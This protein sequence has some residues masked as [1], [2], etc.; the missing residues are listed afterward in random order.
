MLTELELTLVAGLVGVEDKEAENMTKYKSFLIMSNCYGFSHMPDTS[1]LIWDSRGRKE[2][3]CYQ[4]IS[5]EHSTIPHATTWQ[6]H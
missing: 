2:R 5:S 6:W 3:A 1:Y 4:F